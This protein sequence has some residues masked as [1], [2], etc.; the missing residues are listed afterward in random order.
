MFSDFV[1]WFDSCRE[2]CSSTLVCV[3][4]CVVSMWVRNACRVVSMCGRA[5]AQEVCIRVCTVVTS[6]IMMRRVQQGGLK[7]WW[8]AKRVFYQGPCVRQKTFFHVHNCAK[9]LVGQSM[10][11]YVTVQFLTL[12]RD[13]LCIQRCGVPF[14]L[15]FFFCC[16]R[17]HLYVIVSSSRCGVSCRFLYLLQAST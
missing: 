17:L 10:F 9:S 15:P 12:V 1:R 11:C 8:V 14:P 2:V 13:N 6:Q 4:T 5:S 7:E 16:D 3:A